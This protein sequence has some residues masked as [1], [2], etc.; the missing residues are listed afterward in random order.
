MKNLQKITSLGVRFWDGLY[1]Y[2][3]TKTILS[4]YQNNVVW[5]IKK[6]L[7]Q[8]G[9]PTEKEINKGVAIIEYL[10][11]L[12]ID[13]E[14]I[15]SLSN[16]EDKEIIDPSVIYNR[17]ARISRDHWKRIIA[18]GEQTKTLSYY[19]ISVLKVVIQKIKRKET[20]DVKRLQITEDAI[21][22]LGKYGIKV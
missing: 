11:N 22:K 1:K 12:E 2:N 21:K 10:K 9:N 3:S 13:F 14:K 7:T 8:A 15:I 19:E 6:K 18:I 16:L 5:S 4:K 17:L 20:L